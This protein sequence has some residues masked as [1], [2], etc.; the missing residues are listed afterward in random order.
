MMIWRVCLGIFYFAPPTERPQEAY[1]TFGY[2]D[3]GRKT[4][5]FFFFL[6]AILILP[7]RSPRASIL[8]PYPGDTNPSVFF[9]F[10]YILENIFFL[11][12]LCVTMFS[13]FIF[14]W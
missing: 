12:S 10:F 8:L 14:T 11:P 5:F 13:T 9:F 1:S 6:G 2:R 4:P 3:P 7:P